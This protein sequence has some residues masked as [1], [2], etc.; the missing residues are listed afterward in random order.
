[1]NDSSTSESVEMYLLRISLLQEDGQPVPLAQL[2]EELDVSP[3]SANQMCRKLEE[4]HLV[5]YQP[6]KG[7]TL[8]H[9]GESTALRVLRKRRLWEVF[10]VEKLGMAPPEAE[11]IAC[12][13]EHVTPDA[14][15]EQLAA[16]LGH[17]GLSPQRQP[18]P[19]L[20][21]AP[22]LRLRQPL[23]TLK[24]GECGQVLDLNLDA[25]A[26]DFLHVQGLHAG[27][28]LRVLAAGSAGALL[29]ES[30]G[31]ATALASQLA[32]AIDVT[33]L[34]AEDGT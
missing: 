2:A 32:A 18:I 27:A 4:R 6:Y 15:G 12:R 20:S 17:P 24:P 23:A 19:D 25:V 31:R 21:A 8:T 3:V 1:M 26:C 10:L 9:E 16:Y 13:F 14:L 28:V 34:S 5:A 22:T 7:V 33:P 11:E 29:V 30:A